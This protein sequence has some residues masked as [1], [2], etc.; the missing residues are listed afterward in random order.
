MVAEIHW[1]GGRIKAA[2]ENCGLTQQELA[3][4]IGI[5]YGQIISTIEKGEREIKANEL[6]RI[7]RALFKDISY[8]LTEEETEK[9]YRVIWRGEKSDKVK[10]KEAYFIEKC[11][12]YFHLE[13]LNSETPEIGLPQ[14]PFSF[15]NKTEGFEKAES[16]AARVYQALNLGPRPG[17]IL[18]D[19]LEN[20]YRLKIWYIDLEG[21]GSAASAMGDFGPAIML[22]RKEAPWR[23]NFSLAHELFHLVTWESYLRSESNELVENF[24]D[25]FASVLLLPA[26]EVKRSFE[27]KINKRSVSYID[28][29]N[30]AREF[31]VSA[32]AFLWRLC[33]LGYLTRA[34]VTDLLDNDLFKRRDREA[35]AGIKWEEFELPKRF[36]R[37]GVTSL[38]KGK[39]SK[40]RL[41]NYLEVNIADLDMVLGR[42]DFDLGSLVGGE[43]EISVR[44]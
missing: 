36:V 29:V 3:E 34:K 18:S 4:R 14:F 8:F 31:Y 13:Q 17:I 35:K 19:I 9:V 32:E 7:A 16:I 5:K 30:L 39:L 43:D 42:Y 25:K 11:E 21:A 10:E 15:R 27:A 44:H 37:L 2:R 12:Q 26:E 41:A 23:R 24:A 6:Y 40:G 33:W 20:A 1:I 38:I 22:N 28:M